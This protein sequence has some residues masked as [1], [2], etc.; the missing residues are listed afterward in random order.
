MLVTE[1]SSDSAIIRKAMPLR[2][3][4]VADF[5]TYVDMEQGYPFT[6]TG[7][8]FRFCQG[9]VHI[10]ISNQMI[11]VLD[12]DAAGVD[13]HRRI[14]ALALPPSIRTATLPDLDEFRKVRTEGPSGTTWQDINGRAA[15]LDCYLGLPID[16]ATVRWTSYV[17]SLDR[18]QGELVGGTSH[19]RSFLGMEANEPYDYTRLDR[20]LETVVSEATLVAARRDRSAA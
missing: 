5:F 8:L 20:V 14:Q 16:E 13:V 1:G 12:N 7:N 2:R 18:Y 17:R 15:S 10:E 9:L 11:F 19:V 6:G 3:P 4:H